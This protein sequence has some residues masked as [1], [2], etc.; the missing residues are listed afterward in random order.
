MPETEMQECRSQF[1]EMLEKNRTILPTS[2][3]KD[4]EWEVDEAA[5]GIFVFKTFFVTTEPG[6]E[7][8]IVLVK[9][10][11]SKEEK[12]TKSKSKE[13]ERLPAVLVIPSSDSSMESLI[14]GRTLQRIARQGILAVGF[15]CRFQG[16][17]LQNKPGVSPQDSYIKAI[18]AAYETAGLQQPFLYDNIWDLMRVIDFLQ[19]REDVDC[20]AI[21][22]TG[23]LFG[24]MHALFLAFADERVKA[25]APLNGV[26]SFGWALGHDSWEPLARKLWPVFE[27]AQKKLGKTNVDAEV[28]KNVWSTLCPGIVDKFD[29]PRIISS[30]APRALLLGQEEKLLECPIK[31]V[32]KAHQMASCTYAEL[33]SSPQLELYI[34]SQSGQ[35]V[36]E[37]MW[38]KVEFFFVNQLKARQVVA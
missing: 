36:T 14:S 13:K 35:A 29:A 26:H 24:G 4:R 11:K 5:N 17:R 31:G 9:H 37:T 10:H 2:V 32:K 25:A 34:E 20:S 3:R 33:D 19:G 6:H 23:I 8:P 38:S 16:K 18:I 30:I 22:V 1:L 15:D 12:T 28:A 7:A 21:G 27:A